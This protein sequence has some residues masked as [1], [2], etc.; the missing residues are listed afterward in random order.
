MN[1]SK[2]TIG[3]PVI[4]GM[5]IELKYLKRI[6]KYKTLEKQFIICLIENLLSMNLWSRRLE[7]WLWFE[8]FLL[9]QK[10]SLKKKKK[11]IISFVK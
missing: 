4:A 8:L 9:I 1:N 11:K 10:F 7:F 2:I 6:C 5:G 3:K